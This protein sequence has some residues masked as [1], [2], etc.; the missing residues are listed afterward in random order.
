IDDR[1]LLDEIGAAIE[2]VDPQTKS[3]AFTGG[4][5]L[6]EW[7]GFIRL[8]DRWRDTLPNTAVHVLTNGRGFANTEVTKA[9]AAVR[10]PNLMAGIPIYSAVD[11]I[12][13]YVVQ[14]YGA[15]DE[16]VLGIL[17]LK[18]QGQRVEIRVVLHGI[19]APRIVET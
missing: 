9:W 13:K 14:A 8:L 7:R 3:F 17:K 4:E 18:D 11:H 12:H 6:L 19:T 5:P 16:T 15:F 1:W 2:L 10:H